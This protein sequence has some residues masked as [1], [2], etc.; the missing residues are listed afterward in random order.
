MKQPFEE[1]EEE[2]KKAF[3]LFQIQVCHGPQKTRQPK[4]ALHVVNS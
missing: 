4:A 2:E 3:S 1:E